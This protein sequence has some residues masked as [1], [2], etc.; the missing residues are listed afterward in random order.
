M[1]NQ[2]EY[3]QHLVDTCTDDNIKWVLQE[4]LQKEERRVAKKRLADRLAREQAEAEALTETP[5]VED[6]PKRGRKPTQQ[7]E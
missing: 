3:F 2:T 4:Q 6:K 1:S 7:E 5:T